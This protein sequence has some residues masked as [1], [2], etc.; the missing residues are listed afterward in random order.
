M[1]RLLVGLAA[2]AVLVA[3]LCLALLGW[4]RG[5]TDTTPPTKSE[6]KRS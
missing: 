5:L 1:R 6:A 4:Q 2:L 3:G